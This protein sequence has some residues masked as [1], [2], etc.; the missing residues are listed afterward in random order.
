MADVK[1]GNSDFVRYVMRSKGRAPLITDKDPIGWSEDMLEY[2]R[3]E[4]YHG[5]FYSFTTSLKFKN[6]Q[7]DYIEFDYA[8]NG[9]NSN[10]SITKYILRDVDGEIKWKYK[11]R[12]IVDYNTRSIDD[13]VLSVN[14]SSNNLAELLKSHETD[15]FEIERI[16]SIDG[17]ALDELKTNKVELKGRSILQAGE[18]K[19][20][21]NALLYTSYP[22]T[23]KTEIVSQGPDRHSSVDS[24]VAWP[25]DIDALNLFY[26]NSVEAEPLRT[27]TVR[28]DLAFYAASQLGV[29]I[30][31]DLVRLQYDEQTA[32]WNEV[33]VVNIF[34]NGPNIVGTEYEVNGTKNFDVEHTQGL[35]LRFKGVNKIAMHKHLLFLNE[36]VFYES[37]PSLDFV[38]I[39]DLMDRLMYILTGEKNAFYSKYFGNTELGYKEDGFGGLIGFISGFWARAFDR[40]SEK[41]KSPKISIKKAMDS[42]VA[43]FNIGAGIQVVDF[44]EIL[45]FEDLKYYYQN[46]VSVTLPNQVSKVKRETDSSLFFSGMTFGC[47]KAADYENEMGLDEPNTVTD[48]VTPIRKSKN[49]YKKL[50]DIRDDDC[51]LELTRRKPQLQFPNEDTRRD[52]HNWFLDL[53]RILGGGYTQNEWSDRLQELP[54]GIHSPETYKGMLFTPLQMLKRHAWVFKAGMTQYDDKYIKHVNSK[55]NSSLKTWFKNENIKYQEDDDILLSNLER[56]RFLAEKI[57]FEH[58]LNDELMDLL[59]G[60]TPTVVNGE[61]EEVPNLYF[62]I[63]FINEKEEMETGYVLNLKRKPNNKAQFT[64]Q[65][66][67]ENLI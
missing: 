11:Y 63:R 33:E 61:L 29:P 36:V 6:E 67:N 48:T 43:N 32:S 30:I 34:T 5:L 53:K 38:F 10:L 21:S 54:S 2:N 44:K 47:N 14:F 22:I 3:H 23:F 9:I 17:I 46:R 42:L 66:A 51:G 15:E 60:T 35:M 57:K 52:D 62:K 13:D 25:G 20:V 50:S 28:Y 49:K 19:G 40:D 18:S 24:I 45:R 39:H 16:D 58:D 41:Y 65:K 64:V 31:A 12:A 26:T 27:I 1:T 8:I 4:Q 37:S 55:A 56:P 59:E 7:K